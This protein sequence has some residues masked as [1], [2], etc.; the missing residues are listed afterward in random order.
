MKK[1]SAMI[2]RY[3]AISL[4]ILFAFPGLRVSAQTK[5][6]SASATQ[7]VAVPA[8]ITQVID[9]TSLATLHRSVHPLAR[10][11]FD[12]G[13]APDS[14][15][16]N[17]ML[18]VLQRSP[19]QETALRNLMDEQQTRSLPNYHGWLT[20][21][22]FGQQFGPASADIQKVT[23]WL[24]QKGFTG[25]KPA[26][27]GMF[28]EFSGTAG[29]VRNAFHT[30]LH[31]F[32]VNG[33]RHMANVS[34]PQIPAALAPVVA[35]IHSLHDFRQKSFMHSSK[36]LEK[37]KSEGKLKPG[38]QGGTALYAVGAGDL[39]K[40]YNIPAT[41]GT[42]PAGMGQTV[43][44]VARSNINTQDINDYGN[45][46]NLANLKAFTAAN[47]IIVNGPDPGIVLPDD[48]EATLDVEM[49]GA[50]APNARI[51][52]VV[53][54]STQTGM[55]AE[56]HPTDGADQ[57]ALYIV[58]NNL[59]PVM[60][61]SFGAC[62]ADTDTA[63]SSTLWEQAAAQGITVVV[64]AGDSGSDVCDADQGSLNATLGL[65]VSGSASTPFNVAV[66]GTD[67]DDST[68]PGIYWNNTAALETAKSYIPEITW[69][70][71]CAAAGSL[72]G[73]TLVDP[74]GLDLEGG[75]G[76]QSTCGVQ[77]PN[78]NAC[79]GGYPKPSWQSAPGVPLDTVRDIPDVSLF[80]AVNSAS[81]N[82]YIIC[83]ADSFEQQG[84]ACNLTGPNFNFDLV[85][86]T[87]ASTQAFAGM[88]ALVNQSELAAGRSGRQ[89]NANYVLYKL[90]TA[91]STSPG[92]SACNSSL[93]PGFI[94]A[95]CIFND[96]TKGNNSVECTV[97][98]GGPPNPNCSNQTAGGLGILLEPA[99]PNPPFSATTPA[100]QTTPGYDVATGLG[101]VNASNLIANWSTVTTNFKAATPKIT[102]P[103]TGTVSIT[104]GA[105][106]SF[107][108]SVTPA[109]GTVTP[110]GDVSLI[111]EPPGFAQV[112][113][114]SATLS[115]SGTATISTNM[116]PGDDTTGAGTPYP[117]IAHY[118]GDGT[119][120]PSDSAPINVTVTRENS[121]TSPNIWASDPNG[122]VVS[123]NATS[124][125]YGSN[126]IMVVS[127]VGAT[128]GTICNNSLN[129]SPTNIPVV[130]CPTGNITL[131]DNGTPLNDFLKTG[132][133]NTNA[134]TVGNLGFVEDLLIQLPVGS[135]NGSHAIVATYSG[136]NSYNPSTSPPNTITVTPGPTQTALTA[137]GTT[138]AAVTTA[139]PAVT[140]K[141]A[142]STNYTQDGIASASAGAGPTGTVTFS[143]CGT[144]PSCTVTVVPTAAIGPTGA[145][146]TATLATTFTT[147]GTQT[148]TA[149]YTAG[150][151]NYTASG[152]STAVTV[153]VT[154]AQVGTFTYSPQPLVLSSATGAA[155]PL[156]VT[157]T[158]I[159]GFT[160]TVAVTPTAATLPPGVSCTPSPLNIN[161]VS[162]T[163]VAGQFM[164]MVT[165]TSTTLTASSARED[166]MFEAK[167]IPPRNAIP[168]ATSGKG[169][170]TLSAG[171][172][173]A[174]LFLML[175][176]GGRKKYRAALGLGLVCLLSFA[177]GCGG[178]GGA[179][180]PPPPP[181]TATVTKLTVTS[182]QVASGNAFSFSAAVT[183]GTP[184]G[185]V[186][187][188]ENGAMIGTAATVAGGMATPTAP[189][190][191]V[192]THSISAHYL[193]DATTVASA[194]GT[195][196]VTV[197]GSTTV[198]I[199][200]SPVAAPAA[201]AINVAIQ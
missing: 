55:L 175:L 43:A 57:S 115:S 117:I 106:Q 88:M 89:G 80:A 164:C 119:F 105:T 84:A 179:P 42:A 112:G 65:S 190:L 120:G 36:A 87:S 113:V 195:L 98:T 46:F 22:Q 148:I 27:S 78:T 165:A 130:P 82:S 85:G 107:T 20:P 73:C 64:S 181:P 136:D 201:P 8:R 29:M 25:I 141:A 137:N 123:K 44:I 185:M 58:D 189:A 45:G 149:T 13:A 171:T 156:T 90:A 168:R 111:A 128:A 196:N 108:I 127:V 152:P 63:F 174:A 10:A 172:G 59:A 158:P 94:N 183:G 173:L 110:S 166:R 155:V 19:Q 99:T 66:G 14:L 35:R 186:E 12:Q 32:L 6:D 134:S 118:A 122:N 31:N 125:Q 138:S 77:D 191:S 11:E 5:P 74:N 96:I 17:R 28:I 197:T 176:P 15:P 39:A 104:H 178:G 92:T 72:T 182:G 62:E 157:V 41:V 167:A 37:A 4:A 192:G 60:S 2:S 145:F 81:N 114:G 103:A 75:G 23:D 142:I 9:E 49:V 101:S 150:D 1:P 147:P 50:V 151:T 146:A 24:S 170:W 129:G 30:E 193:G 93:G 159:V 177:M 26:A 3:A 40:I 38:F 162:A 160:G 163:P 126:Y 21:R 67:F 61:Q 188:F 143:A 97:G 109:S 198:A 83:L 76:G 169:W 33:E 131:T 121:T 133:A 16:V 53:S 79:T 140:L 70:D 52:L 161:V 71:S 7:A 194:S 56:T 135:N 100:W 144:A 154:Q 95:N 86:G 34:D 102:S 116:L 153:T 18:L 180:A 69:N 139:Q 47:N 199:T 132:S 184:T 54:G 124:V 91:Q 187:L 200:T 48:A 68:N 51:L